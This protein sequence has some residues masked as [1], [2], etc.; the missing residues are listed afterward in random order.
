[1]SN[2]LQRVSALIGGRARL[3]PPAAPLS[4]LPASSLPVSLPVPRSL[5]GA[6]PVAVAPESRWRLPFFE[7]L[8]E[9]GPLLD[10]TLHDSERQLLAQLDVALACDATRTALLP[11]APAVIPAL[12]SS[13]RDERQSASGLAQRVT[14]DPHLV[15]EVLRMANS[16]QARGGAAVLDI[17][18]AI[19]RLGTDGLRR[20]IARVVLKPVFDSQGDTLSARCA[21]R[22]W[23]HSEAKAE[24]C[25][26]AAAAR[27]LD[28]FEGYLAGLLHNI[29]W[30]AA[31][32][33][34]DRS[35]AGAPA[36]FSGAFAHAIERR[37]ESFFALLVLP[38]QLGDALAALAIELVD[39]DLDDVASPLGE[40][41]RAADERASLEMLGEAAA[42][43]SIAPDRSAAQRATH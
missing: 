19:H 40:A 32:R 6:P 25:Q 35:E 38:W 28:P 5:P 36:R 42:A 3:H 1:M 34:I 22:L 33:A 17:T 2:W 16:A 12:L 41:L 18:E 21:A 8:V 11:R 10:A 14:R 20:A 43:V 24:A 29:G 39:S 27:G 26:H 31:L 4:S 7:W 23:M 15:A 37:R 9:S 13:L 30:T